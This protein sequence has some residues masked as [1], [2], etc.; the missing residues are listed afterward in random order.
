MAKTCSTDRARLP[1][2]CHHRA[3][4]RTA[5]RWYTSYALYRS[6]E[7]PG[8]ALRWPDPSRFHPGATR[9]AWRAK[10]REN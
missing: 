8:G 5:K 4:R 2:R 3:G 6:R 1:R 10:S 7:R 9:S